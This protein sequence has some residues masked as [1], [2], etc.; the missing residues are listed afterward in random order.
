VNNH[1][2]G[3]EGYLAFAGF[4]ISRMKD[5]REKLCTG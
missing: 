5:L 1:Y 3:I 2:D 4:D